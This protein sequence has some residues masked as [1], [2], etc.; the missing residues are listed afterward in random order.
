MKETKT[1]TPV[2]VL[3]IVLESLLFVV[4]LAIL[5]AWI[6]GKPLFYSDSGAVISIFTALSILF[7]SGVRLAD[8]FLFGWPMPLSYAL[9]VI[10]LGGNLTTL[11]ML[12]SLPP[13]FTKS[14][15]LVFTSA[16]TSTGLIIFCIY[17][18]LIRLR[19]TPKSV[20]IIDDILLHIALLPVAL[21]LL[22]YVFDRPWYLSSPID[23]RIGVTYVEMAL[24]GIYTINAAL[25]NRDLFLWRFLT[26]S[27]VNKITFTALVINQFAVPFLVGSIFHG[28]DEDLQ[29]MAGL[30]VYVMIAGAFAIIMFLTIQAYLHRTHEKL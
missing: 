8:R 6:A 25:T 23:P 18:I 3:S 4:S 2:K 14:F 1:Y 21:G 13:Q 24:L 30:E 5:L 7:L 20:F 15:D 26:E 22:A 27:L 12:Y 17:E 28:K 29:G 19:R 9:L 10:V 11:L 16:V